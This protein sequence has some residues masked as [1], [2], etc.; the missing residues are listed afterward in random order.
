MEIFLKFDKDRVKDASYLT[1]GCGSSN[2]CGSF[3][4]ELSFGKTPDELLDITGEAIIE[5]LG[6]SLAI[7]EHCAYLAAETLQEALNDF[8]VKHSG[9]KKKSGA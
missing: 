1:D 6:K 7:E 5:R 2:L 9:Q 3:A 4:V 8:M